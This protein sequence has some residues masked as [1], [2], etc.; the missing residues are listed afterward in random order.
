ML[1]AVLIIVAAFLALLLVRAAL[2]KPP[3]KI[4]PLAAGLGVI[5]SFDEGQA[6]RHLAG[7]ISCKTVLPASDSSS[8][9]AEAYQEYARLRALL[10]EY[11]PLTHQ[12]LERELVKEHSLLYRWPG[13]NSDKPV[14]FMAHYDVV[15]ATEEQWQKPPFEGLIE[16]GVIWGRGT[17]DTKCT[18]CAIFE[19]VE[20]YLKTDFMPEQDIYLAF[21]HDEEI[22]GGGAPAMV[23]V[24]EKRGV[25][26]VMVLDE[27]G[28]IV[29]DVFP[30]IAKP[31]AVVGLEEKGVMD[32]EVVLEGPG[33]H[34][35]TP[36]RHNPLGVMSKIISQVAKSPFKAHLPSTL[37]SMFATLGGYMPFAY[38]IVFANLWCFKPL[39][40]ALLPLI[41][42]E[43]NALCRTTCVFTMLEAGQASNVIPEKVRAVANLRLAR[44]DTKEQAAQYIKEIALQASKKARMKEEDLSLTVNQLSA[45]DASPATGARSPAFKTLRA[46]IEEVFPGTIVTPYIMLGASDARHYNKISDHVLRFSPLELS[47]E[48]LRS[49]HGLDEKISVQQMGKVVE[50]YL[51]I[52]ALVQSAPA[53]SA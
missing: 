13:K 51:K 35:S 45:H 42:R 4:E 2:L 26:P 36:G 41:S 12:K 37:S 27:G 44:M 14:L 17:L 20:A 23:E 10:E 32:L 40:L 15:P 16:D 22:M 47:K 48:G 30:G 6:A 1:T 9:L 39:L 19:A 43:L 53:E 7:L 25:R 52:I 28:A 5:P 8:E 46:A 50:F 11:Y 21:G 18:L 31:I 34:S 49:I 29:E 24:L 3:E 38:K 33:G